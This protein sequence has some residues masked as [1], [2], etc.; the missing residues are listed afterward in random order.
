MTKL[1]LLIAIATC[2]GACS[3]QTAEEKGKAMADEKLGIV[4]GVG[5]ALKESGKQATESLAHGMGNAAKGIGAG[6]N[7]ASA[8]AFKLDPNVEQNGINVN[9]IQ[10][11]QAQENAISLYILSKQAI[12]GRMTLYA[13]G[14]KNAELGRVAKEIKL[15]A[16]G[17][18]YE[19][20][21]FDKRVERTLIE[22][23]QVN[24]EPIV[25]K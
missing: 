25:S 7:A 8:I 13:Y 24:F 21:G 2:L 17:A 19:D 15:S 12:S 22:Y 3:K 4:K 11:G 20:F 18:V 1:L 5:E 16:D 6:L 10:P 9:R 23:V 14:K